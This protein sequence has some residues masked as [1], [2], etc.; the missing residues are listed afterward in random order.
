MAQ[1]GNYDSHAGFYTQLV[2]N[3]T[4]PS[5]AF[6]REFYRVL[7]AYYQQNGLYDYLDNQLKATRST[8]SKVKSIR[9]PAWRVAE[10][11]ASKLFPGNL[12]DALPIEA[13][14]DR[15]VEPIQ[16]VWTWSN[17]A[18]MKQRW[19]R[20]FAI[21]GD[22]FIKVST[23][24]NPV[25]SVYMSLIRPEYVTDMDLDERG[26]LTY[27]RLDIPTVN[28]SGNEVEYHTEV[29]DKSTQEVSIWRHSIGLDRQLSEM[30]PPFFR[31]DF[32]QT[33]G[34]DFIPVVYQPFRDDGGGRGSGAYASQLEKI[35]EV[36][37]QATRLSQMLF[38]YNRAV[39][40]ATSTGQDATGRPLP[41]ISFSDLE[42]ADGKVT[43]GDDDIITLP[44]MSDLQPLVPNINYGDALKVL[45]SQIA[46]L[47]HD[48]PE[49]A[50]YELRGLGEISGRAVRFL[51]DDMIS[52]VIEARGNAEAAMVRAQMMALTI[53]QNV[54]L[55]QFEGLGEFESGALD[56]SFGDRPVLPEDKQELATLIQSLTAAGATLFEAARAAGM[57]GRKR[58]LDN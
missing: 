19:A 33:H 30:G 3:Q 26:F 42:G 11:Y 40:A 38:R 28:E 6:M 52:R 57:S 45:E 51:L 58:M 55:P 43:I 41:P 24:G 35:D 49:L 56:H 7:F 23:K 18:S 32:S 17:F 25:S 50:Y 34:E 46:E 9:N 39:W 16:Q 36:N 1:L 29:W 15:I 12:P 31:A 14:N 54:G 22:W 53:G 48:L 47:A 5:A 10:F 27:L 44:S 37:R 21:F 13:E 4:P 2:T 20:W 8:S